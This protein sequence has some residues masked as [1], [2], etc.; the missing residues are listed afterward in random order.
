MKRLLA[1]AFLTLGMI[2][3]AHA[4]RLEISA[5][6]ENQI[7]LRLFGHAT[8]WWY[9]QVEPSAG[10]CTSVT[11]GTTRPSI[12]GLTDST[13][14]TFRAYSASGCADTA[15]MG[16]VTFWTTDSAWNPTTGY[17]KGIRVLNMTIADS[18][19][20]Y[21]VQLFPTGDVPCDRG[22]YAEAYIPTGNGD[23]GKPTEALKMARALE[24]LDTVKLAMTTNRP[25]DVQLEV[26]NTLAVG[27]KTYCPMKFLL[28]R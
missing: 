6:G 24:M 15:V 1:I 19:P 3:P 16:S 14:H 21:R 4:Q 18:N 28:L 10:T 20:T 25:V 17:V 22:S 23:L 13:R 11:D 2:M 12:T 8:Q 9:K 7:Q 27:P 26:N 5:L